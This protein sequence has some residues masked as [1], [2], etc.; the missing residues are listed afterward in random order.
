MKSFKL[1]DMTRGW[2][3]GNFT[4]TALQTEAAEVAVKFYKA[5]DREI[6]HYHRIATEITLIL[7]GEVRMN[8]TTWKSGD[9]LLMEPNEGTDFEALT[10]VTTV[11]V[12][13]P[14]VRGDK[15]TRE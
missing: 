6:W 8:G 4:P 2:F 10:A 7:Q 14:S 11:V 9:I 3:V 15:F 1:N 5:G 12:K 13:V